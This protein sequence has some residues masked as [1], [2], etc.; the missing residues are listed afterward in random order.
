MGKE[1]LCIYIYIHEPGNVN[2]FSLLQSKE[3]THIDKT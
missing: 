1:Y 2:V 3:Y